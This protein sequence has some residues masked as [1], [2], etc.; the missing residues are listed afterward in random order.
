MLAWRLAKSV[1]E[2]INQALLSNGDTVPLLA[3]NKGN[4]NVKLV[5][6]PVFG[7]DYISFPM[8][9]SFSDCE[10]TSDSS[11]TFPKMPVYV[12]NTNDVQA[13]S[14]LFISERTVNSAL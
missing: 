14:Q 6:D 11:T 13:Q 3:E 8:D 5:A 4:L 12:S 2:S 10:T 9:G 1:E 7:E